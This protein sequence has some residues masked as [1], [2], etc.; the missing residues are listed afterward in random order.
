MSL[1]RLPANSRLLVVK[2][3]RSQVIHGISTA[4]GVG[5]SSPNPALFKGHLYQIIKLF[6]GR[7][8]DFIYFQ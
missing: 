5:V 4:W 6:Q 7:E 2:F 8:C 1:V 3:W